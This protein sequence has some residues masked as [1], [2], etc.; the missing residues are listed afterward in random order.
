MVFVLIISKREKEKEEER[1][2]IEKFL[3]LSEF[4][5]TEKCF[6]KTFSTF[7]KNF[8]THSRSHPFLHLPHLPLHSLPQCDATLFKVETHL[9]LSSKTSTWTQS[10]VSVREREEW[11]KKNSAWFICLLCSKWSVDETRIL[12]FHFLVNVERRQVPPRR[13][14]EMKAKEQKMVKIYKW[15]STKTTTRSRRDAT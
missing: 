6:C 15:T 2:E 9:C 12:C 5:T 8:L 1:N 11:I 13:V 10:R 7:H 4:E 3:L 14:Y